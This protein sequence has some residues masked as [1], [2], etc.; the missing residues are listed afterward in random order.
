MPLRNS[1]IVRSVRSARL[2]TIRASFGVLEHVAPSVSGRWAAKLWCTLPPRSRRRPQA[3]ASVGEPFAVYVDGR[4]IIGQVFGDP[5]APIAYLVHGWGGSAAQLGAFVD[6][7]VANGL[8]VIAYD[9]LSHGAS[10]PG[11][12]GPRRATGIELAE[13]FAAVVG[14]FG[15]PYVVVAHSLGGIATSW[16]IEH[17]GVRPQRLALIAP[18]V[19]VAAYLLPFV[20]LLGGGPRTQRAMVTVLEA[21]F[22][23]RMAEFDIRRLIALDDLP[24]L[25]VAHDEKDPDTDL[26]PVQQA[27]RAVAGSHPHDDV[28]P[29][30]QPAPPRPRSRRRGRRVR[31]KGCASHGVRMTKSEP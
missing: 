19:Q 17:H 25:L 8:Q 11:P 28:W 16:A 4:T 18:M 10:D 21:R 27:G 15:Q 12:S 23:A 7:L 9:A 20:R 30:A 13:A 5:A 29:R 6:P 3:P 1:T 14:R 24:P 31:R 2:G 26:G 22:G